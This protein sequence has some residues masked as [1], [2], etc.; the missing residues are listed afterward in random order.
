MDK[1]EKNEKPCQMR[2]CCCWFLVICLF[3]LPPVVL[4][5]SL[6]LNFGPNERALK[7]EKYNELVSDWKNK[8]RDIFTNSSMSLTIGSSP[9]KVHTI[10]SP[11]GD[12][13]PVRDSCHEEGDPAEGC[14]SV[15]PF[16]YMIK[17]GIYIDNNIT[18]YNNGQM[19]FNRSVETIK[20]FIF[21]ASDLD[22]DGT[23]KDCSIKCEVKNGKWNGVLCY[24]TLYL[25]NACYRVINTNDGYQLDI[26]STLPLH[27]I[28]G[29]GCNY[30]DGGWEPE[31]YYSFPSDTISY[32]IR[33]YDDPSIIAS[34]ITNGC[35]YSS[36]GAECFGESKNDQENIKYILRHIALICIGIEIII[37]L[38]ISICLK[39]KF[40]ALFHKEDSLLPSKSIYSS[41]IPE[42]DP[43]PVYQS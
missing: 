39:S 13:W 16:Y 22:C 6:F 5:C 4:I 29:I 43:V 1:A 18:V 8:D 2:T 25:A 27:G 28:Q 35:S 41:T 26:P 3:I 30:H 37:L 11:D 24:A 14:T 15:K 31:T 7:I 38:S 21:T 33:F 9:I 17:A 42:I 20:D 40:K 12:Y 34:D 32:F 23:T 10:D 36:N 19:I